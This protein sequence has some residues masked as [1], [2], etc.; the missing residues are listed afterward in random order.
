MFLLMASFVQRVRIAQFRRVLPELLG[1]PRCDQRYLLVAL[2]RAATIAGAS[3]AT[4]FRF[5]GGRL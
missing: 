1:Q 2:C 3:S 4:A 5:R